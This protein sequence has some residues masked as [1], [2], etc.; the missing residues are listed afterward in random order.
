MKKTTKLLIIW[1][2]LCSF[3]LLAA[4][5][6]GRYY[7]S[8]DELSGIIKIEL[9]DYDNP[10]QKDFSSWVPD[11]TAELKPFDDEKIS[12]LE[13]LDEDNIPQL[14]ANLCECR[15]LY[16]YFDYDSPN[17]ICLKLTYSNGDFLIISCRES[18]Y[19][20]YI[21]KFSSNGEVAEFIGCFS[22]RSY[23][24]TLVNDFFLTQM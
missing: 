24:E 1:L 4:C 5:D 16:K 12:V 21:G 20:G 18:S 22:G 9:I 19:G 11:H 7:F 13:T 8:Q 17:G 14:L 23:F 15:I 10:E 2:V 6:P 3:C